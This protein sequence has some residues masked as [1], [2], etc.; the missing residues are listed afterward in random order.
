MQVHRHVKRFYSDGQFSMN[1][2][3]M[4][5]S[6]SY[7]FVPWCVLLARAAMLRVAG[8]PKRNGLLAT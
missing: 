8:L 4:Y 7:K 5:M 3:H 2:F 6:G 1:L